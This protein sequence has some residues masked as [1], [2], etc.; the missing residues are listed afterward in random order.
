MK[1]KVTIRSKMLIAFLGSSLGI[2]ILCFSYYLIK[3]HKNALFDAHQVSAAYSREY[4]NRTKAELNVE[5]NISETL[6]QSFS[7]ISPAD[8]ILKDSIYK[9]V[10][11]RIALQNPDFVSVWLNLEL[12]IINPSYTKKCGRLRITWYRQKDQLLYKEEIIDTDKDNP[13][14]LY[15]DIKKSN[16]EI[17]TDPYFFSYDGQKNDEIQETS[18]CVPLKSQ[19]GRFMGLAG[20]DLS[21]ERFVPIIEN[22]KPFEGSKPFLVSNNGT[23]IVFSEKDKIGK[24]VKSVLDSAGNFGL[25]SNIRTG[26][27][28]SF[29]YTDASGVKNYVTLA[30]FNIGKA[31]TPWAVGIITP[32]SEM[33]KA[34]NQTQWQMIAFGLLGMIFLTLIIVVVSNKLVAPLHK[35]IWFAKE[36]SKG[37]LNQH[38]DLVFT[39]E[40]GDLV[41]S[42]NRMSRK[43]SEIISK[44]SDSSLKLTEQGELLLESSE[45]ISKGSADQASATEEVSAQM[46]EMSANIATSTDNA[47]TTERITKST[48]Q[49]IEDVNISATKAAEAMQNIAQKITI[50]GDIAF[51]TNILAL[52]AAVEAARAGEQG[53]GFAVVA[54]EVRKL[55]ERSKV[56]AEEIGA[57]TKG[58]LQATT[59]TRL[60]FNSLL[61]E[62]NRTLDLINE[63]TLASREQQ[64]GVEQ[65]NSAMQQLNDITQ[66]NATAADQ[67]A[68]SAREMN[69]LALQLTESIALFKLKE[70]E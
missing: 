36:I 4:A 9:K 46:E 59:E 40:T 62:I 69:R 50:I 25:L 26:K 21:L 12:N 35:S 60:K 67:T 7:Q 51:Q 28:C 22:I 64:M 65:V 16:T 17:V 55:A 53:K 54:T 49:H 45:K 38:I 2:Y 10:L 58:S 30:S 23:L 48:A 70:E 8:P 34:Y 39:D 27:D 24:S 47:V 57:L 31:T 19:D 33:L 43:L 29:D 11:K 41:N 14:G 52:N 3:Y 68:E 44:I 1:K 15:Y 66:H 13:T 63:I 5:M 20:I 6:A 37:D 56:A 18:V 61:P 32:E 42:L